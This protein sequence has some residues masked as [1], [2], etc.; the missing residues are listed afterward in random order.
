M[1]PLLPQVFAI[2]NSLIEERAGLHYKPD[3]IELVRDKI[4]ARAEAAGFESL[5]DYYYFLRY[6]PAG[7][8][9]LDALVAVLLV[10]ETF[11][12]RERDGLEVLIHRLLA[13][14]LGEDATVRIWCA[15]CATGEEPLSLAMMLA[16][17]GLLERVRILATDLSERALAKAR[18]GVFTPRSLRAVPAGNEGRWLDRHPDRV[19]IDPSLV[20]AIDWRRLNLLDRDAIAGLGRF[21]AILAR[22]VLIYFADDTVRTVVASLS[23]ALVSGGLLLVGAAESLLRYGTSLACEEHGGAF[24]YRRTQ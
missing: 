14:R 15:A 20:R 3:D 11:F 12:F 24:F 4:S 8:V 10:H 2:L 16:D 22:N 7:S 21:D 23:G 1:L 9:E 17:M 5:L 6:D 13:R 18:A 19:V